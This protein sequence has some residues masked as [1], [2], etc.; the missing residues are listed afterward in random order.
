[1]ENITNIFN[2]TIIELDEIQNKFGY[3]DIDKQYYALTA[4]YSTIMNL[5]ALV[6]QYLIEQFYNLKTEKIIILKNPRTPLEITVT[7]YGELGIDDVNLDLLIN[8]NNLTGDEIY[9]CPAGKEIKIYA[10]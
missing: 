6:M 3:I 5:Y 4:T 9:L 7:E 8:S 10:S 2:N 1:M